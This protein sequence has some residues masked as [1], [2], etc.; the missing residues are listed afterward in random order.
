MRG[1][2]FHSYKKRESMLNMKF[3]FVILQ[4]Q[5]FPKYVKSLIT[6]IRLII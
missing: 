3:I 6:I 4:S 5:L 1:M 2:I